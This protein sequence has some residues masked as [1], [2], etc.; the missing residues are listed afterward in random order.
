MNRL[1]VIV[2]TILASFALAPSANA[3]GDSVFVV[4]GTA[5]IAKPGS[6]TGAIGPQQFNN[7]W[8][9]A[10]TG[11]TFTVTFNSVQAESE[12]TINAE[13]EL[14]V[15]GVAYTFSDFVGD[16]TIEKISGSDYRLVIAGSG[17]ITSA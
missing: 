6:M 12:L 5:D 13:G 11:C 2:A 4:T 7:A 10:C 9:Y 8:F 1:F 14:L 17:T 3:V 16:L 15:P